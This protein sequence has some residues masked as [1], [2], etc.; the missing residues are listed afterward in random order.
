[1]L[2]DA[3]LAPGAVN[4]PL[5]AL[6]NVSVQVP[7][8]VELVSRSAELFGLAVRQVGFPRNVGHYIC[9]VGGTNVEPKV[10]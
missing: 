9:R 4:V 1:M 8:A 2:K 7:T 3:G 10:V 5:V 6:L